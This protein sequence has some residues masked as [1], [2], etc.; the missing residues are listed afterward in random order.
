MLKFILALILAL[1]L[2]A[3]KS[4]G[5][6]AIEYGLIAIEL[7]NIGIICP[8]AEIVCSV[9]NCNADEEC[10]ITLSQTACFESVQCI[11]A[12]TCTTD[13]DCT[14]P[15][16]PFCG[17]TGVCEGPPD[18][19]VSDT[20]CMD[21]SFPICDIDTGMCVEETIMDTD[22]DGVADAND[23]CIDD[24]NPGQE[25]GDMDGIGDA[26][27]ICDCT[28]SNA[29]TE[30]F[31]YRGKTY[32]YGTF[33]DDIICGTPGNDVIF[34]FPGHDCIDSGAGNDR[35]FAG[36][37]HDI[38]DLGFGDDRAWGGWGDDDIDGEDGN[39]YING[40]RGNDICLGES[41]RRCEQ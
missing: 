12:D 9:L 25:D 18:T 28:D 24:P 38:A 27:E 26:C 3:P 17:P 20:D 11:A 31:T 19:C 32:I 33:R 14:D 6:T 10:D 39:D 7:G 40:G 29:I 13:S 34:A 15:S 1:G 21:P 2:M 30:G 8:S 41:L 22:M 23:N 35:V 16:K 37:G 5:A 4:H 36:F